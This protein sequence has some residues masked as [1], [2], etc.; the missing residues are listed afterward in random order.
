[1]N[2]NS[3]FRELASKNSILKQKY[4]TIADFFNGK[5]LYDNK[6]NLKLIVPGQTFF[7]FD[8]TKI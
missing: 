3:L 8:T 2:H 4:N 6:E 1:M 5:Y 7:V